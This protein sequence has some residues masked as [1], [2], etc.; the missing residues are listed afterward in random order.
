MEVVMKRRD[1]VRRCVTAGSPPSA[2]RSSTSRERENGRFVFILLRG[3]FDGLPRLLHTA[4]RSITPS[5]IVRLQRLRSVD[6]RRYV[7]RARAVT[8]ARAV[9]PNQLAVVMQWPSARTRSHFDGQAI[10]ETDSI[11]QPVPP[12]AG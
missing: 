11:G 4:T 6:A 10:L 1:F 12:M 2:C 8:T 3:G 5:A 9:G 7:G